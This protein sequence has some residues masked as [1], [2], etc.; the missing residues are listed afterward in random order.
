[1]IVQKT[2]DE[3]DVKRYVHMAGNGSQQEVILPEE[4]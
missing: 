3:G 1:M 4:M 2:T